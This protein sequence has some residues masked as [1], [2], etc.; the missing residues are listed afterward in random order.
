M[1]ATLTIDEVVSQVKATPSAER[2]ELLEKLIKQM[3]KDDQVMAADDLRSMFV[4]DMV[5]VDGVE[6]LGLN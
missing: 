2:E 4:R 5:E 6:M 1:T 3:T